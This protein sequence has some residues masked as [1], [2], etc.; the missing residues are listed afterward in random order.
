MDSQSILILIS[1]NFDL[2]PDRKKKKEADHIGRQS[3]LP[4][5]YKG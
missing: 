4:A 3:Q 1:F 5:V 2:D